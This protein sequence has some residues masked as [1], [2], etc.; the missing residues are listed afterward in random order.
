MTKFGM[1]VTGF[2]LLLGAL[3]LASAQPAPNKNTILTNRIGPSGGELFLANGDGSGE[4]KLNSGG[5][6]D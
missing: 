6:M 4:H 1:T 2:F 5:N 3:A